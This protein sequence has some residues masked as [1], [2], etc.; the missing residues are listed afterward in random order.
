MNYLSKL[1]KY[2]Q[3]INYYGGDIDMHKLPMTKTD[4]VLYTVTSSLEGGDADGILSFIAYEY[5]NILTINKN[6]NKNYVLGIKEFNKVPA[7]IDYRFIKHTLTKYGDDVSPALNAGAN[8]AIYELANQAN[9]KDKT[10][11]I[12]RVFNYSDLHLLD[13]K[14]IRD[15]Y[16]E[17]RKYM[18][19]IFYYGTL[20]VLQTGKV[21]PVKLNYI[22]TRYYNIQSKETYVSSFTPEQKNLFL[23]NNI[24]LLSE[25]HKQNCFLGDY[26]LSNIGWDDA[27]NILL[28]DFDKETIITVNPSIVNTKINRLNFNHTY[29]PKYLEVGITDISRYDKFSVGGLVKV[30]EQLQHPT[31]FISL[32]KLNDTY[33][34]ILA[35]D[36]M[37][38]LI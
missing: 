8:T 1:N 30:I 14:K 11:Y 3:K 36:D 26:K 16:I 28:I 27:Y 32:F 38:K 22:I 37:L 23:K 20:N 19:Q 6:R 21:I 2:K 34:N 24:Q 18:I 29:I 10:K 5:R 7:T 4:M 33:E 12:L 25:L 31:D 17:F 13:S 35:Y 9:K 15:Q